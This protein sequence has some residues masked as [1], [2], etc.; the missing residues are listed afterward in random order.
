M[1]CSGNV[2][3]GLPAEK[4]YCAHMFPTP[5]L[6]GS[7]ET[8]HPIPG[9]LQGTEALF[10][11]LKCFQS[12]CGEITST[13]KQNGRFK[14]QASFHVKSLQKLQQSRF[15]SSGWLGSRNGKSVLI[16]SCMGEKQC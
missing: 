12:V 10:T 9:P 4:G 13:V 16:G 6:L 14:Q 2:S 3:F 1:S 15:D 5:A 11:I 7:F 8:S